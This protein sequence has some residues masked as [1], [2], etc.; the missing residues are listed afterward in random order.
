MLFQKIADTYHAFTVLRD[1]NLCIDCDVC[2]GQCSYNVHFRDARVS[3]DIRNCVASDNT[4]CVGCLRCSALCPTGALSIRSNDSCNGS[5]G[6]NWTSQSALLRNIYKQ[7]EA[8]VKQSGASQCC[9]TLPVYWDKLMLVAGATDTVEVADATDKSLMP[10]SLNFLLKKTFLLDSTP[11]TPINPNL[12]TAMKMAADKLNLAEICENEIYGNGISIEE[13]SVN[14]IGVNDGSCEYGSCE[15]IR[16]SATHNVA[17]LVLKAVDDGPKVIVIDGGSGGDGPFNRNDHQLMP[18]ELAIG[19]VDN[20]LRDQGIRE[21]VFIIAAGGIRCGSDVVKA[22]ALGADAVSSGAAMM[23]AAGCSLC[24]SCYTGK[25]PW[26]IATVESNLCKR[27]NPELAAE[28]MI[29][30]VNAWSQEIDEILGYLGVSSLSDMRGN[31]DKLRAVGLSETE[32]KILGV[33]HAGAI[34]R[35]HETNIS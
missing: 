1:V 13:I 17:K 35:G 5:N 20:I 27:Q 12:R 28:Q 31:K 32:M 19:A 11:S 24:G 3:D 6:L 34:E 16:I 9:S 7:A 29:N 15:Y 23:I 8:G 33:E 25:C 21:S 14:E 18:I 30:V 10:S 22:V 4:K 26:G 2:I